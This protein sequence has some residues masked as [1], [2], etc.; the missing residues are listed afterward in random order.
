MLIVFSFNVFYS[1]KCQNMKHM[2]KCDKKA[3]AVSFNLVSI[4]IFALLTVFKVTNSKTQQNILENWIINSIFLANNYKQ[5]TLFMVDGKFLLGWASLIFDS[6]LYWWLVFIKQ[7]T[8]RTSSWSRPPRRCIYIM[9]LLLLKNRLRF[10]Q[11][12]ITTLTDLCPSQKSQ[13]VLSK[14][15]L[16]ME[17]WNK[18]GVQVL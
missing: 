1:W 10:E 7:S 2:Q 13:D 12:K 5:T 6:V 4:F 17:D 3:F 11:I 18:D 16:N 9:V 8:D 15:T 14:L